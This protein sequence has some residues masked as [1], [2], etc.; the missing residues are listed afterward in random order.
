[1]TTSANSDK[2][3]TILL[4]DDELPFRQI[5]RDI[6]RLDGYKVLEAEDGEEVLKMV[7]AEAPDLILLDIILPR[8][9]GFDVL[10]KLKESSKTKNIPV[11]VY[12]ILN[13]KPEIERA[14]KLGANDFTIKGLTPALEVRNKVRALLNEEPVTE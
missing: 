1:M 4:A 9:S 10:T 3:K 11:I 8:L 2:A 13:D 6:L 7:E 5:Y 14:M 12:S